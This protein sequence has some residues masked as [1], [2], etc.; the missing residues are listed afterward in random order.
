[1]FLLKKMVYNFLMF[2]T[3]GETKQKSAFISLLQLP[4]LALFLVY[5]I[6]ILRRNRLKT[7]QGMHVSLVFL[8]FG[9]HLPVFAFARLSVVLVPVML[10][11]AFSVF[12]PVLGRLGLSAGGTDA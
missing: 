2:W 3:L 8:Y 6:R 7:V 4:V 1:M 5:V 11:Y 9:F 10:V 12:E